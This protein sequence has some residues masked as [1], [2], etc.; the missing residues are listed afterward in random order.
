[1]ETFPV[2]AIGH[3]SSSRRE[4]IDD[5][6]GIVES[7]IELEAAFDASA[8]RG[9]AEFSHIEVV[10]LFHLVDP[11]AV[12][13]DARRPR[14]NPEWPE[15]GIF[16]QRGKGRP[17]RIGVSTCQLLSVDGTRVRV[18]GLDAIDGTPVLDIKPYMRE[19]GPRGE[20]RQPRWADEI[21]GGYF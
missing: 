18:R 4:P 2:A 21:M 20:I 17:N 8:L 9:L 10:Y 11:E 7:T 19:F 15:V 16:A 3:V 5:D 6:W 13:T 1:V 12:T 14:D